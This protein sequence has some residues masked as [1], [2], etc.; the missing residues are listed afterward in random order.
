MASFCTTCGTTLEPGTKAI[1]CVQHRAD[2]CTVCGARLSA[3]SLTDKCAKHSKPTVQYSSDDV[4]CTSCG[5]VGRPRGINGG[6][7]VL[8]VV[9]SLFTLLIPLMLYLFVR[10]GKRCRGCGKK[11]VIPVTSPIAIAALAR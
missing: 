7:L 10:S 9:I 2:F 11:T 4:Y 8:V 5:T 3:D 6:E 1:K